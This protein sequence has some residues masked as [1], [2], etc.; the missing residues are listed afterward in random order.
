MNEIRQFGWWFRKI[1]HLKRSSVKSGSRD[2]LSRLIKMLVWAEKFPDDFQGCSEVKKVEWVNSFFLSEPQ[3]TI[4]S[5]DC[6]LNYRSDRGFPIIDHSFIGSWGCLR[7]TNPSQSNRQWNWREC[8]RVRKCAK[9]WPSR[10][11]HQRNVLK[12]HLWRAGPSDR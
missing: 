9:E 3:K 10:T 11:I 4:D 6:M 8:N 5:F 2:T 7:N 1:Y 12:I